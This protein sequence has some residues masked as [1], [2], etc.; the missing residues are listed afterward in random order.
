MDV[1]GS[2]PFVGLSDEQVA[3]LTDS[4]KVL[5][6]RTMRA[7]FIKEVMT[8]LVRQAPPG[9]G[10]TRVISNGQLTL[11]IDDAMSGFSR[12]PEHPNRP[13]DGQSRNT[14]G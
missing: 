3:R 10:R 14:W 1:S 9:P 11:A 6:T 2:E 7:R 12:R 8:L 13:A 4:A 5:R